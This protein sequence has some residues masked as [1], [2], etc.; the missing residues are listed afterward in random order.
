MRLVG[1]ADPRPAT[2]GAGSAAGLAGRAEARSVVTGRRRRRD[3][4]EV[5]LFVSPALLLY[6]AFVLFPICLACYY[7]LYHWSGLTDVSDFIGLANYQR[8][9][10]DEVFQRAIGHNFTIVALS[11]I[12]QL[13]LALGIALLLNRR[14]RGRA[15]LRLVFFTPYVLSEVI[16][17]V[18]WSLL[19]QPH[20]PLDSVMRGVGLGGWVHLWLADTKIV[21]Y[22][23]FVV[24]T[25]K[26]LGFGIILFLAGLQ[27]I[28][29]ELVEAAHIDG[30]GPVRTLRHVML[31]LLGPTTRIWAFLAVIGSIQLFDLIWIMTVGGPANATTTM[32]TYLIDRGFR[33]YQFGYGNAAAVILFVVCFVFAIGYQ[34]YVLRRDTEGALTGMVT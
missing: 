31:P 2:A 14:L 16:T 9:L 5:G 12:L 27:G 30:A 7:S 26:Y 15:A 17:A 6:A 28:P 3:R 1:S 4:I 33:R 21:L 8:A 29:G 10:Q 11:L 25:W 19:L 20:G 18:T 32:A 22:T 13:P 24:I 34:R 23:M